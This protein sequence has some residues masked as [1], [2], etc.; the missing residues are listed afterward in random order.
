[1]DIKI[2]ATTRPVFLL[3]GRGAV[4]ARQYLVPLNGREVALGHLVG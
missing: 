2:P 1:M 3:V 4:L